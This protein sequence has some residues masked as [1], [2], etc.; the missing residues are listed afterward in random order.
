MLR[1]LSPDEWLCVE[2]VPD[3]LAQRMFQCESLHHLILDKPFLAA[4]ATATPG[5]AI[6]IKDDTELGLAIPNRGVRSRR[7]SPDRGGGQ[8]Q[9][10]P[11][12]RGGPPAP[13][14][15]RPS[16]GRLAYPTPNST[17]SS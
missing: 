14:H 15:R 17:P 6:E 9:R 7:L 5:F 3:Y 2:S 10:G 13:L 4:T 8:H 11:R 12:D 1:M 16:G